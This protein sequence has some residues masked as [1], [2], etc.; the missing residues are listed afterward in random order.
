[1][2]GTW[3][4]QGTEENHLW[5]EHCEAGGKCCYAAEKEETENF[6]SMY[7]RAKPPGPV[8]SEGVWK[9]TRK[10][11][12]RKA[13]TMRGGLCHKCGLFQAVRVIL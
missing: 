7:I 11:Y 9:K 8:F 6:C 5:L 2:Q 10:D 12:S 4:V 1:M 3:S 13:A